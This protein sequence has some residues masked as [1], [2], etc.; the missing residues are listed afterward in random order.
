[1]DSY[2]PDEAASILS[3]LAAAHGLEVLSF[4]VVEGDFGWDFPIAN[5]L[6]S[7][8]NGYNSVNDR[9]LALEAAT[10]GAFGGECRTGLYFSEIGYDEVPA[11]QALI[12]IDCLPFAVLPPPAPRT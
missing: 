8:A 7:A 12:Q 11:G 4:E 9:M 5:I 10:P 3:D 6:V 2:T 1:M